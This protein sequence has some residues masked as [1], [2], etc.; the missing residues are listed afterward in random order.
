MSCC[1]SAKRASLL[2]S[3][4]RFFSDR[5]VPS[6]AA[7]PSGVAMCWCEAPRQQPAY[8]GSAQQPREDGGDL[9]WTRERLVSS[10]LG[11]GVLKGYRPTTVAASADKIMA[12]ERTFQNSTGS[13][14]T[15]TRQRGCGQGVARR[16]CVYGRKRIGY[17]RISLIS[18]LFL[19]L[20]S[21]LDS[22]TDSIKNAG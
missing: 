4:W 16:A 8:K 5:S 19:Y 10:E 17:G 6:P 7:P 1:A 9:I 13:H 11:G 18:Y 3:L 21:D 2:S 12:R 20:C 14:R 15:G 22:N